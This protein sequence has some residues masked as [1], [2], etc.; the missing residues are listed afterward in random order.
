MKAVVL[1]SGGL[2]STVCM[3]VAKSKG[4]DVYPI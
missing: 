2:D 1:L 3:A 4:L